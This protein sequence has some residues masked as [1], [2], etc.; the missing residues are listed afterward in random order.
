MSED[1]LVFLAYRK[2]KAVTET[3]E[4][5]ACGVCRNKMFVVVYRDG[6][7]YPHLRCGICG[8]IL[9]KIGWADEEEGL[10]DGT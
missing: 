10:S 5:I 4:V 1:K 9:G 6:S 3:E 8:N 7:D 2:E